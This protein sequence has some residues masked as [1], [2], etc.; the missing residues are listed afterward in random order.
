MQAG[1]GQRRPAPLR[2]KGGSRN[3][4]ELSWLPPNS[5]H[6]RFPEQKAGMRPPWPLTWL[7]LGVPTRGPNLLRSALVTRK[8]Q[9][10]VELR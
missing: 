9:D 3:Q 7:V 10:L 2:A 5:L 8:Q 1:I 4:R 6:A